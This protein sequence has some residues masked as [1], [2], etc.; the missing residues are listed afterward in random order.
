MP[1]Y[2]PPHRFYCGV[3]PHARSRYLCILDQTGTILFHED[4]PADRDTFLEAVA[5]YRDDLV[6]C[7]ECLFC[8][9]WLADLC[10]EQQFAFVLGYA[11]Y[12]KAIHGGKA[13]DDNIDA[14]KVARLRRGG[15]SKIGNAHLK[16]AFR[17]AACLV[18]RESEQAKRFLQR[19]AAKHGT[20]K[21]LGILD[22]ERHASAD[23][24]RSP[25]LDVL[26]APGAR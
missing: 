2:N 26:I 22:P 14:A 16:W 5:P 1:F 24:A 18:A 3:D 25:D 12:L 20:A 7:C 6:V 21:A 4:L 11:L 13:K 9:Y 19:K 8:W 17:E 10:Q 15:G 23:S